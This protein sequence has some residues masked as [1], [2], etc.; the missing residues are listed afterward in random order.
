M[1]PMVDDRFGDSRAGRRL[2]VL[3]AEGLHPDEQLLS[4]TRAWISRDGKY[5]VLFAAR[6][7]DFVV[8][9][10]QRVLLWSC[11]FFTRMPRRKVFD[12]R[13]EVLAVTP[14]VTKRGCA[15]RVEVGPRHAL[16]FDFRSEDGARNV[17]GALLGR[18]EEAG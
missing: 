11:G 8:L 13:R 14:I 15:I 4:W 1:H 5:N 18:A 6:H 9:T 3:N 7:P 16:R 2:R 10:T 17:A 12:E